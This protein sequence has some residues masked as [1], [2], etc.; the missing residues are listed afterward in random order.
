MFVEGNDF[1]ILGRFA[2]KLGFDAVGNRSEFAVVAVEGFNPERIRNLKIGMETTL[3][4]PIAAAAILDKDYR[5]DGECKSITDR[6]NAFCNY[7]MIYQRKEIE[8]FLLVPTAINWACEKKISDQSRRTGNVLSYES[9]AAELLEKFAVDKKA[10]I[11]AQ[12]LENRSRFDRATSSGKSQATINE[13]ALIEFESRWKDATSRLAIIPGKEAL[14][15]INAHLQE[16]Y[17]V[18]ITPIGVINAM[19]IEEVPAEMKKL[20]KDISDFSLAMVK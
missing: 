15:A 5:S 7:A 8:N 17:G 13:E 12:Y 18:N 20:I 16:K 10:Y 11:T 3:G 6:C 1:Q 4:G 14:S 19:T 2:R 9:D